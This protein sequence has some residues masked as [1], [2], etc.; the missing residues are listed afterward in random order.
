MW[1]KARTV[2]FPE[3]VATPHGCRDR[4]DLDVL[5]QV[6]QIRLGHRRDAEAAPVLADDEV[7]RDEARQR[8]AQGAPA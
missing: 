1:W 7:L 4:Q 2:G 6:T 8:L 3:I 5:R